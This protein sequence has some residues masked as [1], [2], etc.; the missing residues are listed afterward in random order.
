MAGPYDYTVN[1]PQP[2]AQNFLQSL[3]GIQQLKQMQQQSQLAEQQAAIQQQNAAF[4]QQMQPLEMARIKAATDASNAAAS[5]QGIQNKLNQLTLDQRKLV[6]STL[7]NYLNDDTKTVKDIIPALPYLD[8][9][10]VENIGK[11]EQI[12]V[13]REIDTAL[14][15]GKEITANDI[16]GWSNRQ[17]LLKGPEQEQFQRSFLA[18]TPQFQSAAKT[19]MI[20]AV[21][22]AFAGNMGE[23]R[24]AAAEVQQALINSKDSSPAAK[25]VSNSFG[26]IV[27]LIDQDPNL[28]KEVLALNVVNAAGLIGEPKL[29]EETL[30]VYKEFGDLT[31]PGG[32]GKGKEVDMDMED[33]KRQEKKLQIQELQQKLDQVNPEKPLPSSVIKTNEKLTEAAKGFETSSTELK[34]AADALKQFYAGGTPKSGPLY[35][36]KVKAKNF[37]SIIFGQQQEIPIRN[38]LQ[39]VINLGGLGAEAQAQGAGIK[40]NA[41]MNMATKYIP[42]VWN[43]PDAAIE[44]AMVT[45][46]VKDRLAKIN[47][48]EAE[49]N[50]QFR[51]KQNASDDADVAGISVQKGQSK[52]NF[53]T[54]LTASLFP[55]DEVPNTPALNAIIGA[56]TP[57]K[58]ATLPPSKQ[59]PAPAGANPLEAEMR[60]RG[61]IQ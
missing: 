37:L 48:A 49:W 33:L 35:S 41:M 58:P 7:Q 11:A 28:P 5:G 27:D 3:L 46:E 9:T 23:A 21:N 45:A 39:R 38:E 53:I 10:A 60:K 51:S 30:K 2:P 4:Q 14:K 8:T 54:A 13:N 20:S 43:N 40:S 1:I 17:T 34:N 16:R 12:R 59:A 36:A 50:S 15:E 56:K 47:R 52:S 32:A 31:K 44:K 18:M 29:A 25:A 57:A 19:G 55:K 24:K 61:L 22:A 6:S 42:D 26:K